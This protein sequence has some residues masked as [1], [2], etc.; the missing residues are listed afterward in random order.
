MLARLFGRNRAYPSIERLYGAIVAQARRPEFYADYGVPDTVN[1]RFDM[2][3]LHVALLFRRLRTE[4]PGMRAFGQDMFDFF[5]R[6]MDRNLREIGISDLGIPRKMR[7][8][9]EAYYGRAAAYDAG[10]ADSDDQ[11]LVAALL[12][13]IWPDEGNVPG[14]GRLAAYVRAAEAGLSAQEASGLAAGAVRFPDPAMVQAA[15]SVQN[16]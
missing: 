16:R 2:I 8:I 14:A 6:D 12:R 10:L 7:R 11:A 1:G 9:G 3:I 15:A 4:S 13:N 5:C